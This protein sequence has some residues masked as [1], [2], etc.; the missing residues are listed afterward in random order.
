[1]L[2]YLAL[3]DSYT[4]GEQVAIYE[5]FPYQL[6]QQLRKRDI[7]VAAPE[8]VA[9]TGWTSDELMEA[10][11]A[12]TFLPP[13]DIITLLVGVNNQ[14]RGR[15]I[16]EFEEHFEQLVNRARVLGDLKTKIAVLSIPDWGVTPF[17]AEKDRSKIAQEIDAYNEVC[18]TVASTHQVSYIE[19]T[20]SQRSDGNN[21]EFLAADGLH[22]SVK[23]YEKWAHQV[24]KFLLD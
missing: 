14:Y 6:V 17:A 2:T 22:P 8:I 21:T 3:G 20:E 23:E 5:S 4:V 19:I 15:S 11:E 7:A 18:K 24:L 12:T 10:I 16:N 1:M 9:K 13:Y